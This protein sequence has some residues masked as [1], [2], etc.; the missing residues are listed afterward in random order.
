MQANTSWCIAAERTTH[1][2]KLMDVGADSERAAKHYISVGR[3]RKRYKRE[4]HKQFEARA[5]E[6]Y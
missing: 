4:Q 6:H 2:Q 1:H 3:D 5:T